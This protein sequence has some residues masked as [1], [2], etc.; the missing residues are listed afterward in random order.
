MK[1]LLLL[2]LVSLSFSF[3]YQI[4]VSVEIQTDQQKEYKQSEHFHSDSHSSTPSPHS[5]ASSSSYGSGALSLPDAVDAHIASFL[6]SDPL[7]AEIFSSLESDSFVSLPTNFSWNKDSL[8]GQSNENTYYTTPSA[9]GSAISNVLPPIQ[10]QGSAGV[11][12]AFSVI[13]AVEAIWSIRKGKQIKL[14]EQ[15]LIDCSAE[16]QRQIFANYLIGYENVVKN[17][18]NAELAVSWFLGRIGPP[19][20]ENPM[21]F[22]NPPIQSVYTPYAAAL[23]TCMI[24]PHSDVSFSS[25]VRIKQ[26][27][28]SLQRALLRAPVIVRISGNMNKLKYLSKDEIYRDAAA[29]GQGKNTEGHYILLVGFGTDNGVDYWEIRNSWGTRWSSQGYGRIERGKNVCGIENGEN[30]LQLWIK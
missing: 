9:S 29:C 10:H 21:K 6:D 15:S 12:W 22:R 5:S 30:A 25:Y 11:C 18:G 1:F 27:V 4:S 20:V 28:E 7:T 14:S 23:G 19:A 13:S 17:G 2:F 3:C 8:I 24:A 16:A 26:E